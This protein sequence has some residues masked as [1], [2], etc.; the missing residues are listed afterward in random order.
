MECVKYMKYTLKW[1]RYFTY[2]S[3]NVIRKKKNYF[4]FF[5]FTNMFLFAS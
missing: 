1:K 2:I 5:A 4:L 3:G